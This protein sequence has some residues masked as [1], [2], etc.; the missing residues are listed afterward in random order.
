MITARTEFI[1]GIPVTIPNVTTTSKNH[2]NFYISY[3]NYN[4][5]DY[6][7]HDTTALVY[8]GGQSL[9]IFFILNGNHLKQYKELKENGFDACYKY[10]LDNKEF[11]N[12]RSDKTLE[13]G[14]ETNRKIMARINEREHK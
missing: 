7:G 13:D 4:L 9:P 14:Q 10:F 5:N 11:M 12:F 3:N 8:E 2:K 6:G 1:D